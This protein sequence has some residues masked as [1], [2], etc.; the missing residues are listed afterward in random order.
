MQFFDEFFYVLAAAG[1]DTVF[2]AALQEHCSL[3][4]DMTDAGSQ[5]RFGHALELAEQWNA[6]RP[7]LI[8]AMFGDFWLPA[9]GGQLSLSAAALDDATALEGL[10]QLL[11]SARENMNRAINQ[12]DDWYSAVQTVHDNFV[13]DNVVYADWLPNQLLERVIAIQAQ[14]IALSG[15]AMQPMVDTTRQAWRA[16]RTQTDSCVSVVSQLNDAGAGAHAK[17]LRLTLHAQLSTLDELGK[18]LVPEEA[19]VFR[20]ISHGP[21]INAPQ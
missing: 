10:G 8:N 19:A 18:R 1:R 2:L 20:V 15:P 5:K 13:A 11:R 17:V 16:L 7:N 14:A 4:S 12:F 21:A 6:S 3:R 9:G